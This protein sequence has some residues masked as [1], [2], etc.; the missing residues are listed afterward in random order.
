MIA[1]LSLLL[2]IVV[3]GIIFY[4]L[5]WALGAIAL[6]APF[7]KVATVVLVVAAVIVLIGILTGSVGAFPILGGL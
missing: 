2:T 3:W 5:Y 6:P 7:A 1:L 4:I